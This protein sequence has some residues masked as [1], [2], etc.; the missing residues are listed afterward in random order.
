MAG[1]WAKTEKLTGEGA[2]L[3]LSFTRND[4]SS[5]HEIAAPRLLRGGDTAWTWLEVSDVCPAG[6]ERVA[7]NLQV[8][9]GAGT[10]YFDDVY[11]GIEP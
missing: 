7:V 10:V 9:T 1:V 4:G 6:A 5:I 8:R 2:R 3:T 11:L